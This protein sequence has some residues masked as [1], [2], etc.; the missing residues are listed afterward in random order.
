M[1][2]TQQS[3]E[4]AWLIK[5]CCATGDWVLNTAKNRLAPLPH[6]YSSPRFWI[7]VP[8]PPV[9]FV[10]EIL[11]K[12][13]WFYY[14][15]NNVHSIYYKVNSPITVSDIIY[16]R[17]MSYITTCL[18]LY[19]VLGVPVRLSI[20]DTIDEIE[21][22]PLYSS[23]MQVMSDQKTWN[24]CMSWNKLASKDLSFPLKV[25]WMKTYRMILHESQN[26]LGTCC[27]QGLS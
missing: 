18:G 19:P 21:T 7:I 10:P 26:W 14:N 24:T 8:P 13:A 16:I 23:S 2:Y 5:F 12:V 20:K 6:L 22:R 17:D 15:S 1:H 27:M 3:V 11:I 9:R 4:N 25:S